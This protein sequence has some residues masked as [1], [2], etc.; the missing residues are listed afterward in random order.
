MKPLFPSL[1]WFVWSLRTSYKKRIYGF[2]EN[3]VL[4]GSKR[5]LTVNKHQGRL[6]PMPSWNTVYFVF[7]FPSFNR[8]DLPP[9]KSYEQLKEKLMF[10]IEE[11]EGFGQEWA[12]TRLNKC[13]QESEGIKTTSVQIREPLQRKAGVSCVSAH[14]CTHTPVRYVYGCVCETVACMLLQKELRLLA[15]GLSMLDW[16]VTFFVFFQTKTRL[17]S[18]RMCN[19]LCMGSWKLTSMTSV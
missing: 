3:V 1:V 16:Y 15:A 13:V 11:T 17:P 8:L 7:F 12:G 18:L 4:L 5:G 10:A 14:A 2:K 9:Y 6:S 19:K